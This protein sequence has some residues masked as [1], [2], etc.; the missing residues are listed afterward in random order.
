MQTQTAQQDSSCIS[1]LLKVA[2]FPSLHI[3][4]HRVCRIKSMTLTA[5]EHDDRRELSPKPPNLR[6]QSPGP[7]NSNPR[8]M[9][10]GPRQEASV[11]GTSVGVSDASTLTSSSTLLPLEDRGGELIQAAPKLNSQDSSISFSSSASPD[12]GY[13]EVT[14]D[15][16]VSEN[17]NRLTPPHSV[18][19]G[20]VERVDD[21]DGLHASLENKVAGLSL[22]SPE[23]EIV[24]ASSDSGNSS[25]IEVSTTRPLKE[26]SLVPAP[27][28][29]SRAALSPAD[30]PLQ[31][32][33]LEDSGELNNLTDDTPRPFTVPRCETVD[34]SNSTELTHEAAESISRRSERAKRQLL[35]DE[36]STDPSPLPPTCEGLLATT[37]PSN[38]HRAKEEPRD[39]VTVRDLP[40]AT[41]RPSL[42]P[43]SETQDSIPDPINE[44]SD[45]ES[46]TEGAESRGAESMSGDLQQL[47]ISS[48]SLRSDDSD[49]AYLSDHFDM[50]KIYDAS[51]EPLPRSPYTEPRFQESLKCGI[52]VAR[53][54]FTCLN[55][56]VLAM[57]PETQ[58]HRLHQTAKRLKDFRSPAKRR[59]GIVGDSGSGEDHSS[60]VLKAYILKISRKEQSDQLFAPSA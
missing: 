60:L 20:S 57:Q 7:S 14:V 22:S 4:I 13:R 16:T 23:A 58:L 3:Q 39:T 59:I 35:F 56:C 47:R 2:I 30:I 29:P 55:S 21:D 32:V 33:E 53:D 51:N 44:E 36:R 24:R 52:G 28:E 12:N 31:S 41:P 43:R 54:I 42:A 25:R 37:S 19:L 40:N 9:S 45:D 26:L 49:D 18:E 50:F 46:P 38:L 8:C 5:D 10:C 27:P 6:A 11:K 48:D 1:S 15:S 34:S 17:T